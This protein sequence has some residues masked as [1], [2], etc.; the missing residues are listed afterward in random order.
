MSTVA[1]IEANIANSQ[2]ST[3]PRTPEGKA[4]SAFNSTKLGLYAKQAVLLTAEDHQAFEALNATY[5]CELNPNTPVEQTI[6]ATPDRRLEHGKGE[7][8]GS[9]PSRRGARPAAFRKQSLQSHHPP[10]TQSKLLFAERTQSG[11]NS[12]NHGIIN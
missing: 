6:F 8:S 11:R 2:L 12:I 10:R 7:P 4:R 9:R 5:Q 3:G 1:Q